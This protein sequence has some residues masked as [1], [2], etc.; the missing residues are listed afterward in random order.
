MNNTKTTQLKHSELIMKP[1]IYTNTKSQWKKKVYGKRTEESKQY[2]LV[3]RIKRPL[4]LASNQDKRQADVSHSTPVVMAQDDMYTSSTSRTI[5]TNNYEPVW[6][7]S[8]LHR[9]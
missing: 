8:L 3:H 7:L 9:L 5:H 1:N 2:K 6:L 4:A